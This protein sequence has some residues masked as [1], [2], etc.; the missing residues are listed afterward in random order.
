MTIAHTNALGDNEK[1]GDNEKCKTFLALAFFSAKLGKFFYVFLAFSINY[2]CMSHH[3]YVQKLWIRYV[4]DLWS[5]LPFNSRE[6]LMIEISQAK[7]A[8]NNDY[9]LLG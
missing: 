1:W 2:S 9:M 4:E 8:D 5:H 7:A 3:L 6:N